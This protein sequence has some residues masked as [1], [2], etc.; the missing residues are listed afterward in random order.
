MTALTT[1]MAMI[2]LAMALG[3]GAEAQAPLARAV[4]GGLTSS[5]LITLVVVPVVYSIFERKKDKKSVAETV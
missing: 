3:E 5:T 4:L 2:P 1:I